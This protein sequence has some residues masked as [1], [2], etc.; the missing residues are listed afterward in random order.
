MM[1]M[2]LSYLP[3][4]SKKYLKG[5][6]GLSIT[7][8]MFATRISRVARL[9]NTRNEPKSRVEDIGSIIV[10]KS[11]TN[12]LNSNESL[13]LKDKLTSKGTRPRG[14]PR[15]PTPVTV[16]DKFN[17]VI[18]YLEYVKYKKM[19]VTSS[20]FMGTFYELQVKE[21]LEENLKIKS[22]IHQGGSNDKGIDINAI[23]NPTTIFNN[24][25]HTNDG[26]STK[27]Y[28]TVNMKRVKPIVLRSNKTLKLFVQC[29]CFNTSKI[30]PKLIREIKG[31]CQ[32]YF[33]K[34][35]NSAVFMLVSTNGFTKV[36]REDFDKAQIP[37]IY[38]KFTKHRLIDARYPYDAKGWETGTIKGMYFNPLAV[39]MFKGLDWINFTTKL[40]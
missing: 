24:Q 8:F 6:N 22:T 13:K 39:A 40:V 15:K 4:Q 26:D 9:L 10:N 32:E 19:K 16:I 21:F 20:V 34:N 27:K 17:S 37:L 29:K 2:E 25:R 30:A 28:E 1:L 11:V 5:Y 7:N 12:G 18:S 14:R 36:G 31:S 35:G 23:W 38:V 33:R 3:K